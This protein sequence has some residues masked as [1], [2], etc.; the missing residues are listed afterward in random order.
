MA[1]LTRLAERGPAAEFTVAFLDG[2]GGVWNDNRG[3]AGLHRREGVDDVEFLRRLVDEVANAGMA[4]RD[5]L[6]VA[7]ISNGALLAQ[8]VARHGLLNVQ[9]I[10]VG[11]GLGD[12]PIA[13]CH[14]PTRG[15]DRVRRLRR[16]ADPLVPYLGGPIGP[17]G[18]LAERRSQRKGEPARGVAVGIETVAADWVAVNGL[19]ATVGCQK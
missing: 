8:H 3:A 19:P 13:R 16:T 11:R 5:R 2:V 15:P 4:D 6:F 1:G 7:G 18:R 9:G 12:G 14:A 10:R 17:L